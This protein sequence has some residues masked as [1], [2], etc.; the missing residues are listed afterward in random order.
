MID[1]SYMESCC[2]DKFFTKR[3]GVVE[4]M[5]ETGGKLKKVKE[6]TN[7]Q[8]TLVV[9]LLSRLK[10]SSIYSSNCYPYLG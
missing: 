3:D 1:E 5:E 6:L 4:E 10:I 7:R 2:S 8:T 9:K